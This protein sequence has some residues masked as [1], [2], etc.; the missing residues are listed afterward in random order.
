MQAIG[1]YKVINTCVAQ[2]K[3]IGS[4]TSIYRKGIVV[5]SSVYSRKPDIPG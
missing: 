3:L 2:E 5:N 1:V 4:S